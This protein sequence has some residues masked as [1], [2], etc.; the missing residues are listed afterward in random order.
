MNTLNKELPKRFTDAVSKLY[1]A[2]HEGTL[3]SFNC[4]QCAVGSICDGNSEWADIRS[5]ASGSFEDP[6]RKE[7]IE[8]IDKTGYSPIEIYNIEKIFITNAPYKLRHDKDAQFKGLCAVIE[9]LC[10]LDNI[11]NILEY[12]SL[13]EFNENNEAK[14]ELQLN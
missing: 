11:P 3:D 13:F 8:I 1:S 2:F 14:N 4:K 5:C 9:Y 12:T 10:E 7:V 6:K